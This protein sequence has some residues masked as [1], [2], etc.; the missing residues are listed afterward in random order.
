LERHIIHR[1]R[2]QR[3]GQALGNLERAG[4]CGGEG[5]QMRD[6]RG[7]GGDAAML[8]Q[9]VL[10][11]FEGLMVLGTIKQNANFT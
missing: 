1:Q 11:E 10:G 5:G 8:A 9:Q 6:A 3:G 7:D 2:Q 4:A